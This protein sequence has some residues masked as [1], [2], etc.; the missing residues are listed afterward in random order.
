MI[1]T[2]ILIFSM[3]F[4]IVAGAVRFHLETLYS[5]RYPAPVTPWH[6]LPRRLWLR[7]EISELKGLM[8][9]IIAVFAERS[10]NEIDVLMPGYTHMQVR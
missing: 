9:G 4:I 7:K 10:R 3:L 1:V 6:S 2:G 5:A 8:T